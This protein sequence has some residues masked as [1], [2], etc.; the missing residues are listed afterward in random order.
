M[1]STSSSS[2]TIVVAGRN[3]DYGGNFRERL[4]RTAAHNEVVLAASGLECEYLLVEWNPVAGK[5][6]LSEEFVERVPKSRALIVPPGAHAAYSIHPGMPF[7]EMPAKNA[8]I[9]RAATPWI[10]VTNADVLFEPSLFVK[11]TNGTLDAPTL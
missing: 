2:V 11:L 9:P 1:S 7:H 8:G 10:V 6:T 3:D 5:P 4:F